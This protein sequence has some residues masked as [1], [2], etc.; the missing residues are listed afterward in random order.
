LD[1]QSNEESNTGIRYKGRG[2]MVSNMSKLNQ[3]ALILHNH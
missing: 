1:T 3:L 2:R